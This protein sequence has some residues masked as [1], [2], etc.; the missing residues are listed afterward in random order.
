[1]T[2]NYLSKLEQIEEIINESKYQKIAIFKHSTRCSISAAVLNR[3]ERNWQ[4]SDNQYIK[5]YFLDLLAHRNISSQIA[6][7][8]GVEHESPQVLLIENAKCVYTTS[9]SGIDYEELMALK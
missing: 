3:L 6:Q 9:H 8:F 4:L 5:P 2:W 7:T 1:M